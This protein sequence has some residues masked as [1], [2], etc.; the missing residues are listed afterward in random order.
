MKKNKLHIIII[1]TITLFTLGMHGT[2]FA[3]SEPE[4]KEFKTPATAPKVQTD[5][6]TTVPT[7]QTPPNEA[8][9]LSE[10]TNH[11]PPI[12]PEGTYFDTGTGDYI[13]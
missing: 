4:G 6:G 11:A 12:I 5:S 1:A 3:L 10:T 7:I 2:V 8:P 13:D 9:T